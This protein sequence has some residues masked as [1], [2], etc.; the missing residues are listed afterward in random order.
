MRGK[1]VWRTLAK[2]PN[3]V[4]FLILLMENARNDVRRQMTNI[5]ANKRIRNGRK[6]DLFHQ[7]PEWMCVCVMIRDMFKYIWCCVLVLWLP[8]LLN[9]TEY[10]MMQKEYEQQKMNSKIWKQEKLLLY[11]LQHTEL[12]GFICLSNLQMKPHKNDYC[13]HMEFKTVA[14]AKPD[15]K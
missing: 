3:D 7:M 2:S 6:F 8:K 5:N 13:L 10:V 11:Y 12:D 14:S 9:R 4:T 1:E 15:G